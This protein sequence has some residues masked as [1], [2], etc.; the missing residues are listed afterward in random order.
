MLS[1][2]N[3]QGEK[4]DLAFHEGNRK[5]R[6]VIL[7]HG[8]TAEKDRPL[9]VNLATEL[10][11]NGWPCLRFSFSG[12]GNSEGEFTD[13]CISK[14]IADL[15]AVMDQVGSG[16][17]IAYIGHSMGA[18]VG[19]LTAARDERIRVMVS[20]AGMVHT[21]GFIDRE[22]AGVV[23]DQGLMWDEPGFPLSQTYVDDLYHIEDTLSAVQEL[24]LPWLLM[25]GLADDVV[26]VTDSRDLNARLRG[27]SE[28][29]ELAEAD[30]LFDGLESEL[31][32]PISHW[33]KKYL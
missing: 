2:H 27:P 15:Q 16:K 31:S 18:A 4:L 22:F 25:H 26:P 17:K 3:S 5:D 12:N 33:L 14:E 9:L 24:R 29:V 20:L 23:P 28:M 10:A 7:A 6:L 21:R 13:S 19:A 11:A 1:V 32:E 8:V 30:H